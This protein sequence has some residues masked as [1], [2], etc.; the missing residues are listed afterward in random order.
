M[1]GN[2]KYCSSYI[3]MFNREA[4]F[5]TICGEAL[6]CNFGGSLSN[7]CLHVIPGALHTDFIISLSICLEIGEVFL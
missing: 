2:L 3:A 4:D 6:L 5:E 7:I 1:S